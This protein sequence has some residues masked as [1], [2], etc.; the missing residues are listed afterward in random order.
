M[1]SSFKIQNFKSI[2]EERISFKYA[3]GK[4]PNG[5]AESEIIPFLEI[6]TT[7]RF[8][9]CLMFL[10]PN[11]S[12]KSNLIEAFFNF[13]YVIFHGMGT[14]FIPNK[15]NCKFGTTLFE[16][17]FFI[18]KNKYCYILEYNKDEI[19]EEALSKNDEILYEIINKKTNFQ[20]IE[21]KDYSKTNFEN[22][23][24]VECS[25]IKDD[26][27]FQ[28]FTFLSK[29]CAKYPGL[30]ESL[31][32]VCNYFKSK[33]KIYRANYLPCSLAINELA[34]GETNEAVQ[35]SFRRITELVKKLDIDIEEFVLNRNIKKYNTTEKFKFSSPGY[36][37][38]VDKDEVEVVIDEITSKHK[39][40][41]DKLIDFKLTDESFGTQI[42]FEL[43]GIC[44][45]SLDQG[46]TL[47]VDELDRSLH[48][49]LFK[50]LVR[51]FKDKRYNKNNAQLI[52]TTHTTDILDDDIIR[53]SEVGIVS[54]TLK[55]G[56]TLKRLSDFEDIRNVN[57]FRKQYLAGRFSGIPFS[58]V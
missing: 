40:I 49:V 16:L 7:T 24:E 46:K 29:V 42:L 20:K 26:R 43:I 33:I 19:I 18:A 52:F 27:R 3:E 9:P 15:L 1:L 57:N 53:V 32:E 34:E 36:I 44:L 47:I 4:A 54:K 30:D 55:T 13:R 35:S 8:V 56:T 23:L 12:G 41:N 45:S 11:A 21:V 14:C 50:Q 38:R 25:I 22:L 28:Q 17:E 51:L 58:Y 2:L 37:K 10:G 39:D 48:P 6:N 31:S 5:Y